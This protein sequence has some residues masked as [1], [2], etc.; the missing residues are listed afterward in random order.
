MV[1]AFFDDLPK[2]ALAFELAAF[3]FLLGVV[4]RGS[5]RAAPGSALWFVS[6]CAMLAVLLSLRV[7]RQNGF[8]PRAAGAAF[9]GVPID[10]P[11]RGSERQNILAVF[12][13]AFAIGWVRAHAGGGE[14]PAPDFIAAWRA[15]VDERIDAIFAPPVS[16]WISGVLLG[17]DSAFSPA[18]REVFLKTGASHLTAVSGFNVTVVTGLV[19]ALALR[20]PFGPRLRAAL[21][22]AA[23]LLFVLM[24]GAPGSVTRA[25]FMAGAVA[26]AREAA[27]R[28][29]TPM[30]ALLLS[31]LVLVAVTPRLLLDD[32]GFRLS[33]LATFGL[34]AFSEPFAALLPEKTP[35]FVREGFGQTLGA[36][37]AVA[38]LVAAAFGTY[39]AVALPANVAVM[40]LIP[41]VTVLGAALLGFGFLDPAPAALSAELLGPFLRLPLDLL[42]LFAMTPGAL[43][44]GTPAFL[45]M[46]AAEAAV[47]AFAFR[48]WAKSG[49]GLFKHA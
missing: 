8:W 13:T 14:I 35:R 48:R 4:V 49:D 41:P 40:L 15:A 22:F 2:R 5:V 16:A 10:Q 1:R 7:Q 23:V 28:A 9:R 27:G 39:S 36:T 18:W 25:A 24:T 45:A 11:R 34:V 12:I 26:L 6:G 42:R 32:L 21:A 33:V 44:V 30:R 20:L 37:I 29:V 19:A 43:L 38:P 3:A 47:L 46:A 31:V 17:D